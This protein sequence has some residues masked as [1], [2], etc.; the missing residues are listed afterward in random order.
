MDEYNTSK[1]EDEQQTFAA[2]S[3]FQ[4]LCADLDGMDPTRIFIGHST[5]QITGIGGHT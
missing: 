1:V 4:G 5:G 3:I 2:F